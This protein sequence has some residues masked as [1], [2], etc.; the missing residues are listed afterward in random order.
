LS[1]VANPD[2]HHVVSEFLDCSNHDE[3]QA[4]AAYETNG[5]KVRYF[6]ALQNVAIGP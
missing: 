5:G 1:K 3:D 2:R 6:S 4:I